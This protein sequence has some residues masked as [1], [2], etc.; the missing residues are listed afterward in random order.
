MAHVAFIICTEPN[1]ASNNCRG[2][3]NN[4][5]DRN[6]QNVKE[7]FL[8]EVVVT[9]KQQHVQHVSLSSDRLSLHSIQLCSKVPE[10][11]TVSAAQW[12]C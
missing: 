11:D 9:I 10:L 4:R 12:L 1:K 3:F 2:Q 5:E 8:L 6:N 7:F